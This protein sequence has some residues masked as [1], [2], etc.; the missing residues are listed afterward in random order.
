FNDAAVQDGRLPLATDLMLQAGAGS[1]I[2]RM[3]VQWQAVEPS[4]TG[5]QAWEQFDT[6]YCGALAAGIQPLLQLVNPPCWTLS[7]GAPCSS[8]NHEPPARAHYPALRRFARS[9]AARYPDALAIQAGNEPNIHQFWPRPDPAAYTEYLREV[10]LGVKS[11][12]PA[13]PVVA[14]GLSGPAA[15]APAVGDIA[16]PEFLDAM[17]RA[18]ASAWMD[19]V[20]IHPYPI[21]PLTDPRERFHP[22]MSGLRATMARNGDA[23]RRVWVT[24]VGLATG[25]VLGGGAITEDDQAATLEAITAELARAA[26]VEVIV[27]HTLLQ[28]L[29]GDTGGS[30]GF[31]WVIP[32]ANGTFRRSRVYCDFA[33]RLVRPAPGCPGRAS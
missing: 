7:A 28:P 33:R 17:Y 29:A 9:L 23:G 1:R 30:P 20:A 22:A 15:T 32:A 24:E 14:A 25:P 31:G 3:N 18:G 26:D 12:R 2:W 10:H 6:A 5:L 8:P 13:M 4:A 21:V 27:F 19:A 11:A 16:A